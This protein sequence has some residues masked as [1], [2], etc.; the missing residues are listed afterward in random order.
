MTRIAIFPGSFDPFTNAH[1]EVVRQARRLYDKVLILVCVNDKKN[2]MFKPDNRVEMI[3]E[4]IE[5]EGWNIPGQ[6][7]QGKVDV[8]QWNGLLTDYAED[9]INMFDV[10]NIIRGLR[11]DPASMVEEYS[12]SQIY[13]EDFGIVNCGSTLNTVFFPVMDKDYTY[14][15]S[16]RVRVYLRERKM[17]HVQ[18]YCPA[19]IYEWIKANLHE[20]NY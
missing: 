7:C 11:G 6:D 17:G 12:L 4:M 9:Y 5:Y 13:Y 1:M 14:I 2:G 3:E 16:S 20:I 18:H 8:D 15:S 10:V 19:P